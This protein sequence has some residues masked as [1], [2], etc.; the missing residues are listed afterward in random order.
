MAMAITRINSR[1]AFMDY[2]DLRREAEVALARDGHWRSAVLF[3]AT[4]AEVLLDELLMH[5][6]WERADRP[7]D[8]AHLF[9]DQRQGSI[10]RVRKE[11]HPLVGGDWSV[12][13][14]GPV[15]TWVK[16]V[17]GLRHRVIHSGYEPTAGEA[18][19]ATRALR[20]LELYVR[21]LLAD[22]ARRGLFGVRPWSSAVS[23]DCGS[24]TLSRA[25]SKNSLPIELSPTGRLLLLAGEL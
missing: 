15:A 21:D 5:L 20:D 13:G 19:R 4:A 23:Q 2:V 6:L 22:L 18:D 1:S 10:G 16:Q 24:G 11:Y 14:E 25:A 8:A 17:A 7:E 12:K 9:V 3:A